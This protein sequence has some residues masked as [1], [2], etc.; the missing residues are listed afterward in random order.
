[1]PDWPAGGGGSVAE[2][3][4]NVGASTGVQLTTGSPAHTK[5]SWA[6]VTSS[7]PFTCSGFILTINFALATYLVDVGIGAAGSEQVLVENIHY[8]GQTLVPMSMYFPVR[9]PAGSRIAV[10]SQGSATGSVTSTTMYLINEGFQG[11]P[12]RNRVI[13]YGAVTADSGGTSI[14]PG[15]TLHTKGSWVQITASTSAAHKGLAM[16]LGSQ[17]NATMSGITFFYD[18]AVGASGSEQILVPNWRVTSSVNETIAPRDT[19]FFPVDIPAGSRLAVRASSN[20]TDA[21]DRLLD[22]VLYGLT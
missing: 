15:G 21:T 20:N 22:V 1:M 2:L 16:V 11:P 6:E 10:R 7:S 17:N 4:A 5:G 9:I 3:G 18:I 12:G 14:D 8:S 13:T 19:P